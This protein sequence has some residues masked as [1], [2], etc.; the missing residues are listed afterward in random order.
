MKKILPFMGFM[1]MLTSCSQ[2][3]K[4]NNVA[5]FQGVIDNVSWKGG[6]AKATVDANNKLTVEAATL[7]EHVALIMP[8]PGTPIDPKNSNTFVKYILGTSTSRKATYSVTSN[9]NLYQYETSTGAGDGQI[10]ISEYD[11]TTISGTFRFNVKNTDPDS[12]AN[13]I[14][15]LQ[16]GVFYKVPVF[17]VL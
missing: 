17:Q 7:T 10:V 8:V 14:V 3:V 6:N 11:G 15:N 13:Q 12:E 9:G 1:L 16:S 5:V 2:D 4:F